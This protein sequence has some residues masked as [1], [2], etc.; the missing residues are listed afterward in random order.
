MKKILVI[1]LATLI[2][3]CRQAQKPRAIDIGI[4]MEKPA[5]TMPFHTN[6]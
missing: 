4:P 5:G 3:F 2:N 6:W 1:T